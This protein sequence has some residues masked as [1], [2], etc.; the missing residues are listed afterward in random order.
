[1]KCNK[2][3]PFSILS[4]LLLLAATP[5]MGQKK[6][7]ITSSQMAFTSNAEL[8]LIK[9]A[10]GKVQGLIDPGSNQFAF[11]VDIKTFQ[12]F[13]SAL[14]REHFNEKYMES[15]KF[16]R[17]RFSGKI[18]EP[19]DLSTDGTYEVRAKGELD[20]HGQKQTRIIK[21]RI[22]VSNGIINLESHFFVP[23]ADHDISIPTI[24]SQKIATEIEVEFKAT[25][26]LQSL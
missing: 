5:L 11:T 18:I 14:Q 10:S 25:L 22:T 19:I 17:A 7:S 16:P 20:I 6:F 21:S 15:E 13:N 26:A 2:T 9:A 24:V 12:G 4:I 23:L 3:C 8:E 1:M